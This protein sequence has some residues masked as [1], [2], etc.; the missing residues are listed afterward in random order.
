MAQ[1]IEQPSRRREPPYLKKYRDFWLSECSA[2]WLYRALAE[3][4]DEAGATTLNKLA[5]AEDLHAGHWAELL[6]RSGVEDLSF[7]GPPWRERMLV[8]IARRFGIERVVPMLIRL[9]AADAGKYLGV[10]EAPTSM[11]EEEVQH[12]RALAMIGKETPSRIA[13][14]ESRHRVS[15]GGAL[16][17]ATFGINDGLVSNLALVMGIAGG[18]GDS[19]TVL[20][21]GV[22]G[23]MAGAF[24][25]ASGEWVSVQ[26][27]RELYE[28]EI[29][30]E[31]EELKAFPEEEEAE[32]ALIYRAKGMEPEAAQK[33]AERIMLRPAVALDTMAREELG[34]DPNDLSSPWVAASSSFF[35]FAIGAL[36]PVAP[37]MVSSGN[38]ALVAA[39]VGS[40]LMLTL[41]G[42]SISLLTGRSPIVSALR[43]LVVGSAAAG[44]TYVVGSLVGAQLG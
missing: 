36:I 20:L 7:D 15:S 3:F 24:S 5:A 43:M 26:S 35:A 42:L 17:A 34:L 23:L 11:S 28:R 4:S 19:Q 13:D 22:A 39:A 41:V 10:P 25:M 31:R 44:L 37:F 29:E 2:A 8:R 16:R 14:I 27:Q 12:G 18:T 21:A 38:G 32:L 40:G 9:E 1:T 6:K 30:I 33:L